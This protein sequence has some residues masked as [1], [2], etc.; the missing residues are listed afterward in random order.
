MSDEFD[1]VALVTGM[2][3]EQALSLFWAMKNRFGWAGTVFTRSDAEQEWQN[4]QFD[5]ATELTSDNPMPDDVWEAVQDS[6]YWHRGLPELM[7]ERGWE[8]VSQAVQEA[9]TKEE[10]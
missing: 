5:P 2:T 10:A 3:E 6:W 9:L 7:T 1:A 4:E 8:L